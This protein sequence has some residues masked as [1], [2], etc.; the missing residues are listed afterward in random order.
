[1]TVQ[2]MRTRIFHNETGAVRSLLTPPF[3]TSYGYLKHSRRP[4]GGAMTPPVCQ[5]APARGAGGVSEA[6]SSGKRGWWRR[7]TEEQGRGRAAELPTPPLCFFSP[8]PPPKLCGIMALYFVFLLFL[9]QVSI[10]LQ[11]KERKLATY[12]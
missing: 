12:F 4:V 8:P 11:T 6:L 3:L 1:M 9:N 2:F 10:S 5:W 7:G